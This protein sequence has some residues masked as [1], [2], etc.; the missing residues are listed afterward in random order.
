MAP[1]AISKRR[2]SVCIQAL[3]VDPGF[4]PALKNL[5]I[6]E[7]RLGHMDQAQAGLETLLKSSPD[8]EVTQFFTWA[9]SLMA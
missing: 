9:R 1:R 8:D 2:I 6:N 7:F 3:E 4:Q 5:S